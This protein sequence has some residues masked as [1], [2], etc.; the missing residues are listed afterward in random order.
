MKCNFCDKDLLIEMFPIY[1][2]TNTKKKIKECIL[3]LG[4]S[5]VDNKAK[6]NY[7]GTGGHFISK[8]KN[9]YSNQ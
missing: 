8:Y 3:K 6:S 4:E 7:I 2:R 5:A 9:F 1:Q